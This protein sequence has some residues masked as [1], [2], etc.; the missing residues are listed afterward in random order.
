MKIAFALFGQP[1]DFENGFLSI[2]KY[3]DLYP[4]INFSFY[5][6]VWWDEKLI[7]KSWSG[8]QI[9]KEQN[10]LD[11][12]REGTIEKLTEL[13]KPV[14]IK[15]EKPRKFD[16]V[17]EKIKKTKALKFYTTGRGRKGW[18]RGPIR[19]MPIALSQLYSRSGVT[20][21]LLNDIEQYDYV[22][23]T[24]YDQKY[25]CEF[26][27]SI[28]MCL[29]KI[30]FSKLYTSNGWQQK[31]P[32]EFQYNNFQDQQIFIPTSKLKFMDVYHNIFDIITSKHH[33]GLIVED[34]LT[35]SYLYH[36][37]N[38]DDVVY[39]DCKNRNFRD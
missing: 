3:T 29:N 2:K 17:I 15:I 39:L 31:N 10:R 37:D 33:I 25:F 24:R 12:I 35:A 13:Y 23:C 16:D 14:A 36:F 19:N 28:G 34:L 7:G 5:C 22:I 27:I 20:N 30:N 21:L 4:S 8:S 6:H 1:R 11:T 18:K 38:L 26:C 32:K 9:A